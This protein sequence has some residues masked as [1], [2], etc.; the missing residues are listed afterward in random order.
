MSMW[1]C[2]TCDTL[3]H[4]LICTTCN[5]QTERVTHIGTDDTEEVKFTI[6]TT[7]NKHE[8]NN[9]EFNIMFLGNN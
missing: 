7:D 4:N 9:D 2:A 3:I 1:Y 6:T 8:K 5:E